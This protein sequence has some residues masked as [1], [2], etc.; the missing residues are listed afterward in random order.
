MLGKKV[1]NENRK[2]QHGNLRYKE[3]PDG[4]SST[5]KDNSENKELS[6]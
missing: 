5:E 3:E 4:N 2:S 6:G 1:N